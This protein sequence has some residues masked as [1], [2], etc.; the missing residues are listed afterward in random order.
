MSFDF[1][2]LKAVHEL[3]ESQPQYFYMNDWSMPLE[4]AREEYLRTLGCTIDEAMDEGYLDYVDLFKEDNACGTACCIAGWLYG[5]RIGVK[6]GDTFFFESDSITEARA[7][8]DDEDLQERL[9]N[10]FHLNTSETYP[11][12][13]VLR[14]LVEGGEAEVVDRL[15]ALPLGAGDWLGDFEDELWLEYDQPFEDYYQE[16]L[17]VFESYLSEES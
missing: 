13:A 9:D 16:A 11:A 2:A 1:A 17:E 8:T 6:P 10:L 15:K 14:F 7:V 12:R 3:I 5:N 4:H